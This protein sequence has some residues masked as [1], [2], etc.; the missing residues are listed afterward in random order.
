MNVHISYNP[1]TILSITTGM[2]YSLLGTWSVTGNMSVV[3]ASHTASVL[4]DGRVLVTGGNS[5]GVSVGSA[6]LYH[7]ST[8]MC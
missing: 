2:F 3:R 8:G 1:V 5:T 6:E 4:S 7:P